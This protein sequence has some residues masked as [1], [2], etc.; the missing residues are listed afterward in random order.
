MLRLK[1]ALKVKLCKTLGRSTLPIHALVEIATEAQVLQATGL[2]HIV[3][4]L[5]ETSAK[6]QALQA[7]GQSHISN[8]LVEA[9]AKGQAL[10]KRKQPKPIIPE[11]KLDRPNMNA[12][13]MLDPQGRPK[14][15]EALAYERLL[16]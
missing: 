10:Q 1:L 16:M 15:L 14:V 3:N 6:G 4:A 2:N 12:S 11:I 5:V 7:I 9:N 8:A 13:C